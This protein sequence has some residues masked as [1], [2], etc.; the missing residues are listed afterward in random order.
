MSFLSRFENFFIKVKQNRWIWLFSIF[1]RITLAFG[2]LAGGFVKIIDERF[3]SGLSIIHPMGSYLNA[4]HHTGY[5]YTFIGIAQILAAVFLLI[6]RMVFL[7]ALLYFPIILNIFLLSYAVRFEGSLLTSPLMLLANIFLLCWHYD[8]LKF[9]LPIKDPK[10]VN[11]PKP[12]K[13]SNKFPFKFVF[14]SAAAVTVILAGVF[15]MSTYAVMPEN[16]IPDC[17]GRFEGS[18]RTTAGAEFCD[19]VHVKG[20]PLDTCLENYEKTPD[21][22]NLNK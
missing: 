16:S 13:Y 20:L 8:R 1:C 10:P 15:A 6:P 11:L 9:I 14:G 4:L 22:I 19:C 21:D 5:Y 17:I 12:I 7:G 3:A 18:N 2:F